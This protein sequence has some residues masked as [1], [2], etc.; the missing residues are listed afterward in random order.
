MK[1]VRTADWERPVEATMPYPA[2]KVMLVG[3]RLFAE[4]LA[5][6]LMTTDDIDVVGVYP[7]PVGAIDH[8]RTTVP[9]II[10]LDDTASQL[11]VARLISLLRGTQADV[12]IIVL[13]MALNTPALATYVRAGAVG[14]ITMDQ[15]LAEL[16]ESLRHVG[17]GRVL[18]EADQLVSLLSTPRNTRAGSTLAPRELQVLQVLATGK[19]TEEAAAELGI[20][21]HTLRTHLKKCMTKM[22]VRSKLE[23]IIL[24]LRAGLIELPR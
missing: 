13:T 8:A 14:C 23:A 11:D 22:D 19:T 9:D 4:A 2:I 17:S 6:S 20:S 21:V 5:A 7:N 10:V 3:A 18:F 12:R 16:I 24:A 1:H 15:T